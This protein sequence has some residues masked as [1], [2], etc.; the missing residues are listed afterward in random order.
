MVQPIAIRNTRNSLKTSISRLFVHIHM[1]GNTVLEGH[2]IVPHGRTIRDIL[3]DT[4]P[5]VEFE[6]SNGY[7]TF[8]SK[9]MIQTV[10]MV[11]GPKPKLAAH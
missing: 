2:L 1:T 3:M 4:R 8:V 6:P 11:D 7:R 5:F 9:A 10:H